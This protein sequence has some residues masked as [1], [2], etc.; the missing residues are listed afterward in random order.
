MRFG[1]TVRRRRA[2]AA[3]LAALLAFAAASCAGGPTTEVVRT[4]V[5]G[6]T[7]RGAAR[8]DPAA[9]AAAATGRGAVSV[10]VTA[11]GEPVRNTPVVLVDGGAPRTA[12][13]DDTGRS[14]FADLDPRTYRVRVLYLGDSHP[15]CDPAGACVTATP[16]S[17]EAR[18]VTVSPGA[19]TEAVFSF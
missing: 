11:A 7:P 5:H 17:G 16:A 4:G 12:V 6:A 3:T 1:A 10:L 14:R 13:T 2:P 18:E 9:P 19:T 15:V 8:V